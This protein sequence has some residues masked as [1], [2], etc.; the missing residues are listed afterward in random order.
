M[1]SPLKSILFYSDVP[2][3][4]LAPDDFVGLNDVQVGVKFSSSRTTETF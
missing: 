3:R 2:L 1:E 4:P